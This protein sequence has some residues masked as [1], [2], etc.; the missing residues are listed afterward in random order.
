[1]SINTN[2]NINSLPV[3]PLHNQSSFTKW[4][5]TVCLTLHEQGRT[6]YITTDYTAIIQAVD[7]YNA[8]HTAHLFESLTITSTILISSG[9]VSGEKSSA[10]K[11]KS[12]DT[13]KMQIAALIGDAA[14]LKSVW[15]LCKESD[16]NCYGNNNVTLQTTWRDLG[17]PD[18]YLVHAGDT[19]CLIWAQIQVLI[20]MLAAKTEGHKMSE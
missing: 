14:S 1:M 3:V 19:V 6:Q 17:K 4:N 13:R 5:R 16:N 7:N 10:T 12:D 8:K 18:I 20:N 9:S 15:E 2:T 11:V